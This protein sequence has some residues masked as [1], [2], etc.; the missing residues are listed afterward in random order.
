MLKKALENALNKQIS[1]EE[2]A[3][4]S[5]L[6]LGLWADQAAFDGTANFFYLQSVEEQGHMRKIIQFVLDAGGKPELSTFPE[7]LPKP[8]SYK[9]LFQTG[10]KHEKA[11]TKSIH[12]IAELAW[13]EKDMATFNFLQWFV[14]EQVEEENQFQTILDKIGI[15]EKHGGSLYMLDR[16][17]ARRGQEK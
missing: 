15:I 10:L 9:D 7:A 2:F 5:Y 17:L 16:E 1:M 8:K 3:A 6:T 4:R 11:V 14:Q 13:K 12:K